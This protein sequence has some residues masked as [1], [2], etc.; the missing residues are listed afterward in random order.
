LPYE[1]GYSDDE[2]KLYIGG[3]LENDLPGKAIPISTPIEEM[4][5]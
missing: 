1:L 5:I 2:E 3:P 4:I